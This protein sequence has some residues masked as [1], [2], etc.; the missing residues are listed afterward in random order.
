MIYFPFK[1][2]KIK[3]TEEMLSKNQLQVIED[4]IFFFFLKEKP[5]PNLGKLNHQNLELYLILGL[6]LEKIYGI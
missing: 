4:I 5:I 1:S 3:A 2:G 6:Q